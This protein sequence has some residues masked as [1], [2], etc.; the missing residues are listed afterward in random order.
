MH[1]RRCPCVICGKIFDEEDLTSGEQVREPVAELIR[2]DYPA[3]D[4]DSLIC[5]NCLEKY[6]QQHI[7]ELLER[8]KGKLSDLEQEVLDSLK[9]HE[10]VSENIDE[11]LDTQWT[12]GERIADKIAEFGGSWT[13]IIIFFLFLASWIATNSF[14]LVKHPFDPYPYILLNLLLSCLAAIQAPIIMMSQNR[15]EARDRRRSEHDYQVNLK[16]ELE[17]QLLHEKMNHLLDT[18]WESMTQIQEMQLD[19]LNELRKRLDRSTLRRRRDDSP[20][21]SRD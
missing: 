8:E 9:H 13:F 2:K 19:Q 18:Q 11:E 12:L 3:W 21:T 4:D 5:D 1:G 10:L 7:Q 6:R 14:L 17:I 16:A 20:S 15:K